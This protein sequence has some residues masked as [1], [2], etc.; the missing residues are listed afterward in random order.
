V[1]TGRFL[2]R[3][4]FIGMTILPLWMTVAGF[5]RARRCQV[6]SLWGKEMGSSMPDPGARKEDHSR[7]GEGRVRY[8][9]EQDQRAKGKKEDFS[10]AKTARRG[11]GLASLEMTRTQCCPTNAHKDSFGLRKFGRIE[12]RGAD[13]AFA[14]LDEDDWIGLMSLRVSTRPLGQRNSGVDGFGY[15]RCRKYAEIVLGKNSPRR[16]GTSSI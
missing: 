6:C 11:D 15:C 7:R 13:D 4:R 1:N 2:S 9:G 3:G 16:C 12:L 5:K 14:F 8:E 10:L